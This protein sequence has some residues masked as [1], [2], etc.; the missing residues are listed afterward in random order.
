MSIRCG[1]VNSPVLFGFQ[2]L[3]F[4]VRGSGF[5]LQVSGVGLRDSGFGFRAPGFGLRASSFGLRVSGFGLRVEGLG[6][7]RAI[8]LRGSSRLNKSRA[9]HAAYLHHLSDEER[10]VFLKT[11]GLEVVEF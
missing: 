7:A 9:P 4:G 3:G 5:G 1:D 8:V 2:I 10:I 11:L 6:R